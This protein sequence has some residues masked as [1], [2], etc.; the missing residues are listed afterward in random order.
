MEKKKKLAV[1]FP[2]TGYHTDKPLLFYSRK[3]AIAQGFETRCI[4]YGDLSI[5][6][7]KDGKPVWDE[8]VKTAVKRAKLQLEEVDFSAFERVVFVSKS[9]G[10][11][12]A[13]EID[14]E[15][16]L[17]ADHIF[18]TPVTESF[19]AIG[20]KGIV[21]HGTAD[22]MADT[23]VIKA[24]CEKRNLPL[25]LTENGNHSLETGNVVEDIGIL[26]GIMEVTEEYLE[27]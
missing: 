3:I 26:R 7:E 2:G 24:E 10:T 8:V 20:N 9:I 22:P 17:N 12:V 15:Q 27:L 1:F 5:Q 14:R 21:F 25:Y 18:Y 19:Q 13:A 11:V 6:G 4:S 16:E 23:A